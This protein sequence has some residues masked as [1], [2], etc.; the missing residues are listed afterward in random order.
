MVGIYVPVL[1]SGKRYIQEINI[2]ALC[3]SVGWT[4]ND[5]FFGHCSMCFVVLIRGNVS[6]SDSS[7]FRRI[8]NRDGHVT[9]KGLTL[10]KR[11]QFDFHSMNVFRNRTYVKQV[12]TETEK[13]LSNLCSDG[14]SETARE[15]DRGWGAYSNRKEIDGYA[16]KW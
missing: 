9:G 16:E 5:L 11:R 3:S 14:D 10:D 12:K 8:H 4:S 15:T 2:F 6:K 13:Q 1:V 7:F